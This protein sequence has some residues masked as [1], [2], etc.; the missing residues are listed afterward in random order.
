MGVIGGASLIGWHIGRSQKG[1]RVGL[2][3]RPRYWWGPTPT[4]PLPCHGGPL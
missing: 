4:L 3:P 2:E 1:D